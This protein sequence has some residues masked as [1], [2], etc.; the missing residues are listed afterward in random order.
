M[1]FNDRVL[2]LLFAGSAILGLPTYADQSEKFG[3]DRKRLRRGKDAHRQLFYGGVPPNVP[4]PTPEPT[5]APTPEPTP[6]P[7]ISWIWPNDW[8]DDGWTDD[9][10]AIE[11]S[12][13]TSKPTAKPTWKDNWVSGWADDGFQPSPEQPV[14]SVTSLKSAKVTY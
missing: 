9:G 6:D 4:A 1:K 13:P 3:G 11:T 2:S 14:A 12:A 10:P 5:N 8:S 7:T